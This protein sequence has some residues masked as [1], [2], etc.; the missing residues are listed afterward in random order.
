[1]EEKIT[2][3]QRFWRRRSYIKLKDIR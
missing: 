2:P 3:S 1:M